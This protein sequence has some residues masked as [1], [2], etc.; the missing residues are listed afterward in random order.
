MKLMH[1]IDF[2]AHYEIFYIFSYE[3][4]TYKK[5]FVTSWQF[6]LSCKL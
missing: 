5:V 2:T 1:S 4:I 6:S 3:N